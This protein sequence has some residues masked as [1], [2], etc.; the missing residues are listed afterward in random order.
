[1]ENEI[2][3]KE[4]GV[5]LPCNDYEHLFMIDKYR[6]AVKGIKFT[7]GF[8]SWFENWIKKN[9]PPEELSLL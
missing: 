5:Y 8:I 7:D 6:G 2:I 9:R 3:K 1:M 4:E